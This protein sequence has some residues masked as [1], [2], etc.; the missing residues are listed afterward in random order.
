M[1]TLFGDKG[2]LFLVSSTELFRGDGKRAAI[3]G[4]IDVITARKAGP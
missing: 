1:R 3:N 4:P 2:R